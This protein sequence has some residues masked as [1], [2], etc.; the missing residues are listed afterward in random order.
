[1]GNLFG[2]ANSTM[3]NCSARFCKALVELNTEHRFIKWPNRIEA[4]AGVTEF[5]DAYGFP[6]SY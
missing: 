5:E 3:L 6:G 4:A 2:V 1:M